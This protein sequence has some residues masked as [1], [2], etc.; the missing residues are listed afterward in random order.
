MKKKKISKAVSLERDRKIWELRQRFYTYEAIGLE[1]GISKKSVCVR[2]SRLTKRYRDR[3]L[4]DVDRIKTEQIA[5]HEHLAH[6]AYQAWERS[7]NELKKFND[8]DLDHDQHVNGDPRYLDMVMK[9][10]QAIRKIVGL[11]APIKIDNKY[12]EFKNLS[13]EEL[14]RRVVE[15]LCGSDE[16]SGEI[17]TRIFDGDTGSKE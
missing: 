15:A 5:E 13:D 11:D 14:Q 3:H 2:L 16:G 6:E 4:D 9:A 8:A 12:A 1:L 17:E 7:K 10:K